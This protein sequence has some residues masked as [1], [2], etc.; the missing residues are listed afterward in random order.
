M[1]E[2]C[3]LTVKPLVE[4]VPKDKMCKVNKPA[5]NIFNQYSMNK[6]QLDK[7]NNTIDFTEK[8]TFKALGKDSVNK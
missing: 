5:L 7:M 8:K 1:T 6:Q 4:M 2:C 3:Q